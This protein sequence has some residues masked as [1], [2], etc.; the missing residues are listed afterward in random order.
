MWLTLAA[1]TL[2]HFWHP[3]T[4]FLCLGQVFDYAIWFY[5]GLL[6]SKTDL[7]DRFLCKQIWL[8]LIVG[9]VVYTIGEYI[10]KSVTTLG[11][12]IFSFALAII[13]DRFFPKLFF[14]FRNYTYQIFLMGIFAQVFVK[15]VFKHASLPYIPTFLLCILVGLYVPVVISMIIKKINYKPLS[16]CVGLK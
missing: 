15:I 5:L 16:L 4:D 12:I 8:T 10:N 14:S 3:Y 13:V 1:L 11:G 9:I 6:I 2:L 7:V